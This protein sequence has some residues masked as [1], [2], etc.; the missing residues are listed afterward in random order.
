MTSETVIA[1]PG[2]SYTKLAR[3]PHPRDVDKIQ[4]GR[5]GLAGSS[6]IDSVVAP[7][8]LADSFDVAKVHPAEPSTVFDVVEPVLT[9]GFISNFLTLS[10]GITL[11]HALGQETGPGKA[12]W[13]AASYS[14]VPFPFASTFVLVSG[15]LGAIYGHQRL[16]LVGL[17]MF[18]VFS[19]ANGFCRGFAPFVAVRALSGIGGG[20]YMPNAIT[21][22][23]LMVPPGPTRTL[24]YGIFAAA[25]PLDGLGMWSWTVLFGAFETRGLIS[26]AS[27]IVLTFILP[28]ERP[29]DPKGKLDVFGAC[30]GLS[31]LLLFN[32]AW[33]QAPAV[34]WSMPSEIVI[35]TVSV[36]VFVAFLLWEQY[37]AS[38]PIMPLNIFRV[39]TFLAMIFVVLFS[40]MS[41]GIALWYSIS[42]QQ[43]LRQL[44]VL[45]IAVNLI[46]FGLGSTAAVGLAAYLLPRVEAKLVMAVGVVAVIGASLLLATMTMQQ[47]YW[48]Q[49]FPAMLLCGCCPDF[50]YL[51]AQVI[52]SNSV[53]RKHQG[54]ASSLFG[55]LN[56]QEVPR[57]G[58]AATMESIM[59]GFKAAL[60]F[61]AALATV[62]MILDFAFVR[63]PKVDRHGW[64]DESIEDVPLGANGVAVML[65]GLQA[66]TAR[67]G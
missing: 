10:G 55:T 4:P 54:I 7:R 33:S 24:I 41:F 64:G 56:L 27:A 32:I 57:P 67:S 37:V 52:A 6:G 36:V 66:N 28:E 47:T 2:G 29:I 34:G 25:P 11:T 50:V 42:W 63:V 46:P 40:Y 31:S 13:M 9:T 8:A 65:T 22:L 19:I 60:Y 18:G 16:A 45:Q 15:R 1:P 3:P 48:A 61:S 59:S 62:G 12:N 30:L 17:G 21:A 58:A 49:V 23:G 44:S 14:W 35:L 20:I 5:T 53:T 43:I 38:E 39:P 51:A 26:V